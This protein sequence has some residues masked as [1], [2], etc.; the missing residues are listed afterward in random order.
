MINK[1]GY[2][3]LIDRVVLF[4]V[5]TQ[6]LDFVFSLWSICGC[7]KNASLLTPSKFFNKRIELD[8]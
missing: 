1:L 7:K 8:Y 6:N 3:E 5:K 2:D 4:Y